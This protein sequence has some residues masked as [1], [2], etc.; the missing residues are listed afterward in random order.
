MTPPKLQVHIKNQRAEF[1][2]YSQE[3]NEKKYII[4]EAPSYALRFVG[5]NTV[6]AM[7]EFLF[8]FDSEITLKVIK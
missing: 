5:M 6:D 4:T 2:M 3:S 7:S 1:D 8:K